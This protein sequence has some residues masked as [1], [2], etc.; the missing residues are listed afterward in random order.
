MNNKT[1]DVIIVGFALFAMFLGAG[2]L[3]F[4]PYLG[5][6][7]GT[8][9]PVNLLG[10]VL[11]GVGLPFLGIYSTIKSGGNVMTLGRYIGRGFS[12]F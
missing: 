6:N 3:I 7:P 8:A 5:F 4:P 1:K 12:I 10:F 11:T 2:N 9:W